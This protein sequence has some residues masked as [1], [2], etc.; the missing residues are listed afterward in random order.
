MKWEKGTE[1]PYSTDLGEGGQGPSTYPITVFWIQG[2]VWSMRPNIKR[3]GHAVRW[4]TGHY[5]GGWPPSLRVQLVREPDYQSSTSVP[6][7]STGIP[8][9]NTSSWKNHTGIIRA[10]QTP[11]GAE[12]NQFLHRTFFLTAANV[13][14]KCTHTSMYPLQSI[15]YICYTL[16]A[17]QHCRTGKIVTF[18]NSYENQ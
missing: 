6:Q 14:L 15:A 9:C 5:C 11:R 1:I 10:E 8:H 17:L 12:I 3:V 16:P 7:S 18:R 13:Y 4:L 2:L